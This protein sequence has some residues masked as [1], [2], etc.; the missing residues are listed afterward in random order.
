MCFFH[1]F[2][3]VFFVFV[4]FSWFNITFVVYWKHLLSILLITFVAAFF[5][6]SN[7][8]YIWCISFKICLMSFIIQQFNIHQRQNQYLLFIDVSNPIWHLKKPYWKKVFYSFICFVIDHLSYHVIIHWMHYTLFIISLEKIKL[9]VIVNWIFH[10]F[11]NFGIF[12]SMVFKYSSRYYSVGR[13]L[14]LVI[15]L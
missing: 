14:F 15:L 9:V 8:I 1:F 6:A 11:F 12:L 2:C 10:E 13:V 5:N 4:V 3:F 7:R